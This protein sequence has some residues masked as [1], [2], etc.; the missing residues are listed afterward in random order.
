MR[1]AV[2]ERHHGAADREQRKERDELGP[3]LEAGGSHERIAAKEAAAKGVERRAATPL[4]GAIAGHPVRGALHASASAIMVTSMQDLATDTG[5]WLETD[6]GRFK[7]ARRSHALRRP[8]LPVVHRGGP[9]APRRVR[10]PVLLDGVPRQRAAVPGD[11][12]RGGRLGGGDGGAYTKDPS[13]FAA[14]T[15]YVYARQIVAQI[16]NVYALRMAAVFLISQA[17][18]WLRTGV[19]PKWL[20]YSHLRGGPR[21]PVRRRRRRSG[22][23]SCSPRGCSSISA[24]ILDRVSEARRRGL[25]GSRRTVRA[26]RGPRAP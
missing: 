20:A 1:R 14:S 24:Y 13:A 23:C 17:T 25:T 8:V 12:L 7:F 26:R 16:F 2:P 21:P 9:G 22:W 6:A 18:L 10:G 5:A 3:S 11:D 15:T 19:M 4:A